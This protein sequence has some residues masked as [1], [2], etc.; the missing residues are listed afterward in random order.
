LKVFTI[1]KIRQIDEF[2]IRNEP[3]TS[4]D[5]MERAAQACSEWISLNY[6]TRNKFI[7][8]CGPGNNGGDGLAIAR[9][10]YSKGLQVK[11]FIISGD[12][13]ISEDFKTSLAGLEE[14]KEIE[15][16]RLNDKDDLHTVDE[17]SI[18][19]DAIF[20]SGLSRP[21]EGLAAE[22]IGKINSSGS[23]IISID[24][25]SGLFGEDNRKNNSE[26][27]IKASHTLTFQFPKL[28]F[29]Y[30]ENNMYTGKWVILPIGLHNEV[31]SRIHSDF[32]YIDQ[33]YAAG[34]LK[35]RNKFSHKGTYGHGL[36]IAGS[37]GM[38]GASVLAS[39]ACMKAGAGLVTAHI[40]RLGCSILQ[41]AVPEALVSLDDSD[42]VFT[43]APEFSKFTAVAVGP[44]LGSTNPVHNGLRSFLETCNLPMI[45]D[46]D[47]LNIISEHKDW[48]ERIPA[49]SILTPHPGEFGRLF[50]KYNNGYDSNH[51]QIEL[52]KKHSIIIVLKGAFTSVSCPDGS[53]W[54]NS[55]GN[56]GMATGG[57]GDVLTGI[58]LSLLAQGYSSKFAAI[59]GTYIHGLAGDLASEEEGEEG[60]V[61]TDII[62]HTGKAFKYLKKH[63][64]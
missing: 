19:I 17:N 18:V 14:I 1:D 5:L 22:V 24:I 26:A 63:L 13:K 60:V 20:G 38:M 39:K 25:P 6:N 48:L 41:T 42:T 55:T 31:I 32:Y 40:P 51:A 33:D 37:Y 23:I 11:V 54:F 27:I 58:I 43:K 53:C 21:V 29:F 10:L 52:S 30:S 59:L 45:L 61:A 46:A 7:V 56:P 50:G 36:L 15:I 57:S 8:F 64:Q 16:I 28:S 12:N 34:L 2:T 3:I 44:G 9:Q 62:N 47:A 49:G 4:I 35:K